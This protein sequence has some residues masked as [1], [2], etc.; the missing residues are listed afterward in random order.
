MM[1]NLKMAE[2]N[3]DWLKLILKNNYKPLLVFI[4]GLL[5]Y[6]LALLFFA[7][8]G[9]KIFPAI[10]QVIITEFLWFLSVIS[11]IWFA[12]SATNAINLQLIQI[13]VAKNKKAIA[14]IIPLINNT[15]KV[16]IGLLVLNIA[17]PHIAVFNNYLPLLQKSLDLFLIGS[18]SWLFIQIINGFE[19]Y[20][21]LRYVE[22]IS[23]NYRARR[24]YTQTRVFKQLADALVIIIA[25]ASGFLLFDA[26]R[27]IGTSLLASAGIL[28]G[29]LAFA[30]QQTWSTLIAGLRIAITQPIRIDDSV[31]VENEVGTIEEIKLTY[32]VVRLWDLRRLILPINYFIE[33]PFQNWTRE[34][35]NLLGP[36]FL[37]VDYK[38]PVQT[39]REEFLRIIAESA[40]WD[41][42]TATLQ[43]SDTN[44]R[45]IELRIL[46]SA[47]NSAKLWDLRCEIR[48]KLI[49]YIN[50]YF[51]DCLPCIRTNAVIASESDSAINKKGGSPS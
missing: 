29:A 15:L 20:I 31:V 28:A 39:L 35:S 23:N 37:H 30:G 44:Q 40:F 25:V 3:L 26:A 8:S 11:F 48:E 49:N 41:K 13:A 42:K 36:L 16:I 22:Q 10:Y 5:G 19:R 50:T 2:L 7:T 51:P 45:T 9:Q 21:A 14:I 43:V 6:Y 46:V 17:L 33:K 34:S 4:S 47:E 1:H 24:V 38:L 18:I 32:V 12:F 27:E